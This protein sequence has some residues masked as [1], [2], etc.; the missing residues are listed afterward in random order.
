MRH[1]ALLA[2]LLGAT[3]LPATAEVTTFDATSNIVTIP[4]V[5]YA[6]QTLRVTLKHQGNYFFTLDSYAPVTVAGAAV[7]SYDHS[8]DT[9]NIPAVKVGSDTYVD[10]VLKHDGLG[11]F[12]VTAATPVPVE[13][14]QQIEVLMHNR[15]ALY[16]IAVP[17]GAAAT[18]FL[19]RCWRHNGVDSDAIGAGHPTGD[20]DDI[21]RSTE[22]ITVTATRHRVNANGSTRREID[23]EYDQ[24]HADGSVTPGVKNTL[25]TGSSAGSDR[26]P[27]D[28]N[29]ATLRIYGNQRLA[30][31]FTGWRTARASG[32]SIQTGFVLT[33]PTAWRRDMQFQVV[34]T[35][36]NAKYAIVSG[37]AI[38][39]RKLL[40][41]SLL[42]A[43]AEL[44]GKRGNYL[45]L[46]IDHPFLQCRSASGGVAQADVANC[47]VDGASGYDHGLSTVSPN[48][49][50]DANF[51]AL[52]WVEQGVYSFQLYDDDGWKTVNGQAGRTPI[53]TYYTLLPYIDS[54]SFLKAAAIPALSPTTLSGPQLAANVNSATPSPVDLSWGKSFLGS[55]EWTEYVLRGGWNVHQGPKSGNVGGA[56]WPA[57]RSIIHLTMDDGGGRQVNWPVAPQP[58][59]QA[60]KTYTDFTLRY[61]NRRT[62]SEALSALVMQ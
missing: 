55:P 37:P 34:D 8:T 49:T 48:A 22:K 10:I 31:V 41:P 54:V 60:N 27:S 61:L 56:A 4:S 12:T 2:A 19:D 53:A 24:R 46:A 47:A 25:I 11:G 50:A 42:R 23:I 58:A 36:C 9:L 3:V 39:S 35:A 44:A 33:P 13:T 21:G 5:S 52:G 32:Y 6:G 62:R 1:A 30:G 16:G 38:G 28:Q 57:Y 29:D 7:A 26:C 18:Q 17:T 14:I 43:A 20:Y 40:C 45:N 51:A 15:D 59:Q